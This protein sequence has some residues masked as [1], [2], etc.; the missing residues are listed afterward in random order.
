[1]TKVYLPVHLAVNEQGTIRPLSLAWENGTIYMIDKVL[2]RRPAASTKVGGCGMRYTVRIQ[3]KERYLF[4]EE[5]RWFV[6]GKS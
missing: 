3:G 1:M 5:G 2:D 6:E 4:E